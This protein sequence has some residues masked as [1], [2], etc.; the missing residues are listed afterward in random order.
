MARR[1]CVRVWLAGR[2]GTRLQRGDEPAT[3]EAHGFVQLV[4]RHGDWMAFFNV[5]GPFEVYVDV[6]TARVW[7]G[8]TVL[9]AWT[10]IWMSSGVPTE[11]FSSST[12][13]SS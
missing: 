2:P 12:T 7:T 4:P 1:G 3:V 6:T 9:R 11:G 5:A 10:S 8:R 13:T